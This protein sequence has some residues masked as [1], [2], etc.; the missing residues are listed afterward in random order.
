M[1][2][3]VLVL[4]EEGLH[5]I[6]AFSISHATL[7]ASKLGVHKKLRWGTAATADPDWLIPFAYDAV[8]SKKSWGKGGGRRHIRSSSACLPKSSIHMLKL[9]FPGNGWTPACHQEAV[10]E[11]PTLPVMHAQHLL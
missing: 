5:S 6:K 2:N 10:K 8:L 1:H 9:C 3:H 7:P 11:C 4:A